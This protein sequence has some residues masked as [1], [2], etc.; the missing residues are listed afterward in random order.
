MC[1]SYDLHEKLSCSTDDFITLFSDDGEAQKVTQLQ[2]K[3]L[4][5]ALRPHSSPGCLS[6]S[7]GHSSPLLSKTSLCTV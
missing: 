2:L 1:L 5:F 3:K 6:P 4:A 7:Y